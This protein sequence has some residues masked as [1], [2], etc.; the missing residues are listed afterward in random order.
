VSLSVQTKLFAAFGL[1]V[2]LMLVLGVFALA[3]LGSDNRQLG[4]IATVV[5]PSTRAVG[6][7]NALMNEYRKDQLHYIVARPSDRPLSAPGSI[8][9]DL[10]GD[11]SQMTASLHAYASQGLAEDRA[12]RRLLDTFRADFL[13]YV[14][15]T[16]PFR[17]LADRGRI[18]EAGEAVGN[19]LGDEQWNALKLVIG[20]WSD[21][22]VKTAQAA[23][24][25][26]RSSYRLGVSLVLALLAVA[27]VIAAAVAV[28]LARTMTRSVREVAAA[29]KA[30][31][32]GD[33]EQHVAVHSGDKF[34]EM[35][36]DFDAMID[37]L[38][39]TVAIAETIAAGNLNVEVRPRSS[40][41][42]LGNALATMTDS[43]RRVS[44]ENERLLERSRAEANT[45]ALTGLPNRRALMRD[46]DTQ[47]D[48][49]SEGREL[50]LAL[51]DLDGFK[52]YNDTFGHPA[53]DA[54]LARLG[55][56]VQSSLQAS[57][58]AYRMGADEFCVLAAIDKQGGAQ[59]AARTASALSERGDAFAV[60]CSYGTANVPQ[61]TSSAA[62]ALRVADDRMYEDKTLRVS[63]SRQSTDVLL[64]ALSER[65]PDLMEHLSG[66]AMLAALTANRLGLAEADLKHLKVAAELHDIGKVAIPDTLLNKPGPLDDEEW[67]FMRRHP[68]IGE[69]II[70]AAPSIAPAAV[71]VRSS[72]ERYDGSGYPDRLA[73]DD[74]PIG[75]SI[76]AVCDAFGAMTSERS[77]SAAIPVGD[78]L[79]E[80]RRC[81]GSQFHPDVVNAFCELVEHPEPR[82]AP[83]G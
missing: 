73:G 54:L 3:R 35:A 1:V 18:L 7:I 6:D 23:A 15:T 64:K 55:D 31:S 75:A 63:A 71:L 16:A 60:S 41:D 51:F 52:E 26:S 29:A 50:M 82:D 62:E 40:Q 12:G 45:D 30:I 66:V 22:E 67:Q 32:R 10:A 4:Q 36:A 28:V 57:A 11:L 61:D 72:H 69:R 17:R 8:A 13:R 83:A 78:A 58:K 70:S 27:V 80:L 43:L 14:A 77:Y 37:Y 21:H 38:R 81:S 68:E 24:V 44:S 39:D 25:A 19:G 47:L 34:G 42:A 2:A 33:I 5:V 20:A 56:R 49:A 48:Q 76:I 79:A 65:N 9:G 59:I 53:G 74:I 46:L